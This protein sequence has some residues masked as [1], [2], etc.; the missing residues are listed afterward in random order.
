MPPPKSALG[1]H[2]PLC[3]PPV[4]APVFNIELLEHGKRSRSRSGSLILVFNYHTYHP[5]SARFELHSP[6]AVHGGLQELTGPQIPEHD[7]PC[8]RSNGEDVTLE[9]DG[10]DTAT[11]VSTRN[12]SHRLQKEDFHQSMTDKLDKI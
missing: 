12:L 11:R 4:D 10:T 5:S 8:S 7:Q 9:G 1:G 2:G 3:P 6:V